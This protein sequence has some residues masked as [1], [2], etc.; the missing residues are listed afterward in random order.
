MLSVHTRHSTHCPK[1]DNINWKRCRCPNWINGTLNGQFIRKT[2]KTRSWEQAE[3]LVREEASSPKNIEPIT[4]EEAVQAYLIDAKA[5]ELRPATLYKLEIIFHTQENRL[6]K[7]A[8]L[9]A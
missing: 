7:S 4:I 9:F 5:R 8:S 2:A 3:E 6:A 1:N